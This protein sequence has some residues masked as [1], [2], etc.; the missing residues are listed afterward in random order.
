MVRSDDA[1]MQ[2]EP[3]GDNNDDEVLDL[4]WSKLYEE[5][6]EESRKEFDADVRRDCERARL[7]RIADLKAIERMKRCAAQVLPYFDGEIPLA[8]PG[9]SLRYHV[10]LC[11][12]HEYADS[13][14]HNLIMQICRTLCSAIEVMRA[15]Q[16]GSSLAKYMQPECIERI[17]MMRSVL[18]CDPRTLPEP[19]LRMRYA[20]VMPTLVHV[21][22]LSET[23]MEVSIHLTIGGKHHCGNMRLVR[24]GS[25]WMCVLMD[26]G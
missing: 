17:E 6:D 3:T 2:D 11:F 22:M 4:G 23:V 20:P 1:Y 19:V 21:M 13:Y 8:V 12:M 25:R 26:L 15:R 14:I 16:S 24:V 5:M 10:Q 9:E 7:A 18:T